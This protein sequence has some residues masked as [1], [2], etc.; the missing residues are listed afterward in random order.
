MANI[1]KHAPGSFCWF[2]LGTS[3]QNAA[4]KFYGSLFGWASEDFPMGPAGVYTIFRLGGRDV[5]ATYTLNAQQQPG[6][7]PH[8][9]VYVSVGSAD[10]A[11][12]KAASLGGKVCA[13]P[14]DVMDKGRM[15]VVQDPAGA[16]F[17]IW[18]PK[19]S[20]GT[21]VTGVGGTACW[22]DISTPDPESAKKF[23]GGLFGW[24][25]TED[26]DDDPPSGYIHIQNGE[27]FIGG[28]PP[29]KFRD[30]HAPP[31]WLAYFQVDDFDAS[32]AKA[33]QLGGR[34]LMPPTFMENVGHIAVVADPQGAVFALFKLA[35]KQ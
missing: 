15:A 1:E 23:Y 17:S 10:D 28:I 14:F 13:P 12:K 11:A 16:A 33:T 24:K 21:T 9:M 2:E 27:E 4:K 20:A 7:P 31:H 32:T 18:Q 8:W 35:R 29:A 26:T 22:V 34:F 30:P 5:G 25:F 19:S 6:V 3:D